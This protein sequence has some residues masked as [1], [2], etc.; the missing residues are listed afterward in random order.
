MKRNGYVVRG[1]HFL[2]ADALLFDQAHQRGGPQAQDSGAG[3]ADF[4]AI[5]G[6]TLGFANGAFQACER[7]CVDPGA[8]LRGVANRRNGGLVARKRTTFAF[9]FNRSDCHVDLMILL[10]AVRDLSEFD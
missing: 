8:S 7:R 2:G 4:T 5:C 3:S 10:P 1:A 6:T 9:G